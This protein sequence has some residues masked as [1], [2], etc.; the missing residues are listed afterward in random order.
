VPLLI[1]HEHR[2]DAPAERVWHVICD[3]SSYPAWN[4]FVVACTSTHAVGDPIAM[5]VRV[6]PFYAQP[7]REWI[8][9]H[10]AGRRLCYGMAD[11]PLGALSSRRWHEVASE[12]D[13]HSRYV[14]RFALTG[15]LA[16]LVAFVLGGRLR[17]G[18]GAMSEALVARAET[19][20]RAASSEGLGPES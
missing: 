20:A 2:V 1:A 16:P 11:L 19:L 5:R 12:G 8:R 7:Q 13:S 9:V 17:A 15:W 3:L 6:L 14:S 10:E 18:F 4:P